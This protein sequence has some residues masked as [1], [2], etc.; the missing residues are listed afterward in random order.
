MIPLRPLIRPALYVL[1]GIIVL[2]FLFL[3]LP[4]PK[5][6]RAAVDYGVTFSRPYAEELGLNADEVLHIALN[7]MGIRRFRLP[8]YWNRVEPEQGKWDFETADKDLAAI[9]AVQGRVVLALG[10]KLPRWPECWIPDWAKDVSQDKQ[11][12]AVLNYLETVV[13]RYQN[14]KT[15]IAWQVENEY[16][17]P[18]G[19]CPPPSRAFLEREMALVRRLDPTRLVTTTD[20]GELATWL[21]AA[22]L[23]DALGVSVYRS[24]RTPPSIGS[25]VFHYWF[26]FP[27]YYERKALF[28]RLFGLKQIYVSEFQMEPWSSRALPDTPLSEQFESLSLQDM[29]NNL[30]YAQEMNVSAID[31]WGLEWWIWMAKTQNHPEFLETM[32]EFYLNQTSGADNPVP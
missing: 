2:F 18:F 5:K 15:I 21:N 20:S 24:V 16:Q 30:A 17:F 1:L 14:D 27:S 11:E 6:D 7:D 31:F 12:A 13:R 19:F 25:F 8:V 32:K 23:E 29:H 26:L 4:W 22:N 10:R 3:S 28:L 9:G